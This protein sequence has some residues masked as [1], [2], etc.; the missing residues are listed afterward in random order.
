MRVE[1]GQRPAKT[2]RI[3]ICC[4][5]CGQKLMQGVNET[6]VKKLFVI[7]KR[8]KCEVEIN[9]NTDAK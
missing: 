7:C 9:F 8:C 3:W 2:D 1:N 6:I 4:P 5:T